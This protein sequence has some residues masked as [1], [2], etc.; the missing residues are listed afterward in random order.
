M[1]D[2][3]HSHNNYLQLWSEG[4]TIGIIGFMAMSLFILLRN[5]RLWWK[6]KSP[7]YLM[8]WGPWLGFMIFGMFDLI[9]DHSA[10]TKAW[11]FLLGMLLVFCRD[12][13]VKN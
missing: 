4:G 10:I 5:F 8:I 13:Q 1:Q 2:L 7:F 12:E 3:P 6:T 11:W 9:I